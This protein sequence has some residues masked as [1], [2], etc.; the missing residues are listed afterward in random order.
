MCVNYSQTINLYTVLDSY[1]FP[2][3]GNLVNTLASCNV[4]FTF[5]LRRAYCLPT[6]TYRGVRRFTAFE[7]DRKLWEFTRVPFGVTDGVPLFQ[8]EMGRMVVDEWLSELSRTQIILPWQGKLKKY[9]TEMLSFLDATNRRNMTLKRG[10]KSLVCSNDQ[11]LSFAWGKELL[12]LTVID[13]AHCTSNPSWKYESAWGVLGL[14]ACCAKWVPGYSDK[15]VAFMSRSL[16]GSELHY[17]AIEKEATAV[18][19]ALSCSAALHVD[20]GS[21][22]GGLYVRQ[23]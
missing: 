17:S 22:V 1:P 11:S 14:F 3:I 6:N 8:R 19:E 21:A 12:N 16:H 9:T 4:F 2:R 10:Q 13:C 7:A 18:I 23:S 15:S 5:H 20:Y